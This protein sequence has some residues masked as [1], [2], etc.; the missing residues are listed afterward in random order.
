MS[1]LDEGRDLLSQAVRLKLEA[2]RGFVM[3]CD[4]LSSFDAAPPDECRAEI[5][6][7]NARLRTFL[8]ELEAK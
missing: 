5:E 1:R 6:T 8:V 3:V 4:A 7:D 2:Q